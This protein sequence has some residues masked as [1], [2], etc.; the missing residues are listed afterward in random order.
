MHIL[1]NLNIFACLKVCYFVLDK[2][3]I[4][5]CNEAFKGCVKRHSNGVK[6]KR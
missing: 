5:C 6:V 2:Q 4:L 1:Y 3:H